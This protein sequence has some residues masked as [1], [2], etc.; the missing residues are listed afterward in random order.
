M[1]IN[2][3]DVSFLEQDLVEYIPNRDPQRLTLID[4]EIGSVKLPLERVECPY[5]SQPITIHIAGLPRRRRTDNITETLL[6]ILQHFSFLGTITAVRIN[7]DRRRRTTRTDAFVTF[8]DPIHTRRAI[9]G[10]N[11]SHLLSSGHIVYANFN[12]SIP[13]MVPITSQRMLRNKDAT[14]DNVINEVN[15]LN[16]RLKKPPVRRRAVSVA[17][18]VPAV[19]TDT[20]DTD[21]SLQIESQERRIQVEKLFKKPGPTV[22]R[23]PVNP[24]QIANISSTSSSS[25]SSSSS[26]DAKRKVTLPPKKLKPVLKRKKAATVGQEPAV[27]MDIDTVSVKAVHNR[28]NSTVPPK[29][30]YKFDS[31]EDADYY[32]DLVEKRLVPIS[33]RELF[34]GE[35]P[36]DGIVLSC[37]VEEIMDLQGLDI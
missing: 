8:I 5:T 27:P 34:P 11:T 4:A 25:S 30:G 24:R 15:M 6:P 18:R 19:Q 10:E 16:V 13:V 12:H 32:N 3:I 31:A 22:I 2:N 28:R 26:P 14:Y 29:Y 21:A 33:D 35:Y 9:S 23:L 7:Y 36:S 37:E 17:E 1:C 20:S